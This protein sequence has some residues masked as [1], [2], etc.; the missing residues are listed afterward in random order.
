MTGSGP[1]HKDVRAAAPA[2]TREGRRGVYAAA[3]RNGNGNGNGK[4]A[5]AGELHQ[6]Q[7][8]PHKQKRQ[9]RIMHAVCPGRGLRRQVAGCIS[10][11][12]CGP[13]M[14]QLVLVHLSSVLC[15][16]RRCSSPDRE[17][18]KDA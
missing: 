14:M 2:S 3:C 7:T 9:G 1:S 15:V 10:G 17:L 16:L 6:Q 8:P 18:N 11:V 4:L 5:T 13:C 12:W